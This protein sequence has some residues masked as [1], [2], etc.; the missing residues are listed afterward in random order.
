MANKTT[1]KISI[2][3]EHFFDVLKLKNC[4]VRKLGEA[5]NEIERTEKT[6][7]RYLDS[8]EMPPDLLELV[9]KIKLAQ[10]EETA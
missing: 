2:D 4:S 3:K 6:I 10:K 1:R 5:Y 8:G 9:C 7:R